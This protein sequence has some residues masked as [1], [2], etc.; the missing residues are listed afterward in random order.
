MGIKSYHFYV[1]K[2]GGYD[3]DVDLKAVMSKFGIRVIVVDFCAVFMPKLKSGTYATS[4]LL[5]KLC[6]KRVYALELSA[7]T[8]R[9][10]GSIK[11]NLLEP[12]S[13]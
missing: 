7:P 11:T 5:E 9:L 10:I 3:D 8:L 12:C 6:E 2:F 1:R 13:A 4:L